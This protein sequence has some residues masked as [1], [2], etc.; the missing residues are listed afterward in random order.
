MA[1]PPD[2]C[3]RRVPGRVRGRTAACEAAVASAAACGAGHAAS[4][5]TARCHYHPGSSVTY[6]RDR[7]FP[8]RPGD[9][10][11]VL[12]VGDVVATLQPVGL[13][14]CQRLSLA[15]RDHQCL[16]APAA[17]P[18]GGE[19]VTVELTV[20]GAR[21]ADDVPYENLE[22]P[23]AARP[24][25]DGRL[26]HDRQVKPLRLHT[27]PRQHDGADAVGAPGRRHPR[28]LATPGRLGRWTVG[29]G[30]SGGPRPRPRQPGSGK[31]A[32]YTK[33]LRT[34]TYP[35]ARATGEAVQPEAC[36]YGCAGRPVG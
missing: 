22:F 27:A 30:R 24:A 9:R 5:N 25:E 29:P 6:R 32:P 2:V 23:S 28:R 26:V 7:L 21:G 4:T 8:E 1:R 14:G 35:C 15:E 18:I 19:K 36:R 31:P 20:C 12:A 11:P 3:A 17:P 13:N 33:R 10:D 34:M 16:K